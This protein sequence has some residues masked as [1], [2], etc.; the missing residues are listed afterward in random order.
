LTL[1]L[2]QANVWI[3]PEISGDLLPPSPSA[4]QTN[5]CQ[6]QAGQSG[7]GDGTGNAIAAPKAKA[8]WS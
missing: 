5:T 2:P 1:G 4:E 6:D 8:C 3:A 7:T